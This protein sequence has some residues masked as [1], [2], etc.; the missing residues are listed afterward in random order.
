MLQFHGQF[1]DTTDRCHGSIRLDTTFT[2]LV[3]P[4]S[5]N[6]QVRLIERED[7]SEGFPF[8]SY[9]LLITNSTNLGDARRICGRATSPFDG[10]R[11]NES[12][13]IE[14][15]DMNFDGYLDIEMFNGRAANGMNVG[16]DVYLFQPR[17][18]TFTF[19]QGFADVATGMGFTLRPETKEIECTA[20]L[21]CM[22]FCWINETFRVQNDSLFLMRRIRQSSSDDHPGVFLLTKEELVDGKLI[23]ISQQEVKE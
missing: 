13:D 3:H 10:M 9:E 11:D 2:V 23:M 12:P 17:R 22:G 19:S 21:G 8:Y 7:R 1:S 16:R 15:L 6:A 20:N 4:P 18:G 14:F 5:L